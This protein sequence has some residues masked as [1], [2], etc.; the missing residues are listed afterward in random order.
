M[1]LDELIR[2]HG[3]RLRGL[4]H[5]EYAEV[6]VAAC[7]DSPAVQS[8]IQ[9]AR[10]DPERRFKNV[11]RTSVLRWLAGVPTTPPAQ[12]PSREPGDESERGLD[13]HGLD[14]RM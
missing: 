2:L 5:A 1:G 10:L 3:D 7:G 9:A 6:A 8:S 4:T 12:R 13:L 14:L 11:I